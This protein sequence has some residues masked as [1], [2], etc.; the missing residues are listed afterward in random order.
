MSDDNVSVVELQE[1]FGDVKKVVEES[2]KAYEAFKEA[3]DEEIKE[4]REK[5]APDPTTTAKLAKIEKTLEKGEDLSAALLKAQKAAE[6]N[7][8]RL[9]KVETAIRRPGSGSGSEDRKEAQHKYW[10]NWARGVLF[11]MTKGVANLPEEC[12]EAVEQAKDEYKSLAVTND[13]T[14]GYLAPIEYVQEIIKGETDISF[15][16]PLARVR[17]TMNRQLD[18]PSRTGQFAAQWTSEQGAR[19]ETTGLT[20]GME[21][22]PT[23]EMYALVDVSEQNLEDS[24]FD[25]EGFIRDEATEQFALAEGTAF[26]T[27]NAVGRPEGILTNSNVS[28]QVSGS[29][30]TIADTDGQANGLITLYH[31]LHSNYSRNATWL[32]NRATIGSVRKLK[33]AED[34]YIWVPGLASLRPN[35]IL[36]AAYQEIPDMPVEAA[37][38]YPIAFGDWRRAYTVVDRIQMSMLRDPYTQA[39]SGNVRFLF[40]RR[41]GG[42]TV[43]PEAYQKLKC[44]T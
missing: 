21:S 3:H 27:G 13:A 20:F 14:G 2:M 4:I 26:I 24:A 23:H 15:F 44:S 22:I 9:D 1:Q 7:A 39:T 36:D 41:V 18:I 40:R 33:T 37:N 28:E 38:A 42:Q 25:L 12:K 5:G 19:S 11:A 10:D 8:D 30:A 31:A 6:D 43:L 29:S 35:T 16:R 34:D 32:L 17:Q